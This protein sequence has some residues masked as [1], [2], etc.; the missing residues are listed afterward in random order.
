MAKPAVE[1]LIW[2][3]IFGGLFVGGL[4]LFVDDQGS[5]LGWPMVGLGVVAIVAGAMLIW[6]RSRMPP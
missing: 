4:G 1:K 3:L 2:P 6:V 5:A